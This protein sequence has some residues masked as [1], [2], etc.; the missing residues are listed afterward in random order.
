MR[1]IWFIVLAVLAF[2]LGSIGSGAWNLVKGGLAGFRVVCEVAATAERTGILT[3]AQIV[4]TVGRL[5][6]RVEAGSAHKSDM[7]VIF[8]E[9]RNGCP[10]KG[11]L[12][13]LGTSR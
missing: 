1:V 10:S 3:R 12:G 13:K 2:A 5:E 9:L 6:K 11:D 8:G 4:D 7:N